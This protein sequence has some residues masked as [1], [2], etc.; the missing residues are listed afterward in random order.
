VING[1][2]KTGLIASEMVAVLVR[3]LASVTW[4][5]TVGLNIVLLLI[6]LPI[7]L[8]KLSVFPR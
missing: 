5:E 1:S 8:T 4:K 6:W 3:P 2:Q 7:A